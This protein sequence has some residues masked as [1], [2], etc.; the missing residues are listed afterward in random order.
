MQAI[1]NSLQDYHPVSQQLAEFKAALEFYVNR[2]PQ[3]SNKECIE[4]LQEDLPVELLYS[5]DVIRAPT[6]LF[7]LLRDYIVLK[8][9]EY[10][11]HP[12]NNRIIYGIAFSFF[13]NG[14]D[15]D[16]ALQRLA[17]IRGGAP[18]AAQ[19]A[20]PV[21][22]APVA[23]LA[24]EQEDERR[25]AHN[26]SQRFKKDDKFTGKL[27]ENLQDFLNNY[28]EACIDYSFTPEQKLKYL[29]NLFEGEAKAFYREHVFTVCHSYPE[30]CN[31]LLAK[32]NNI[33][34]QIRVR[35][36]LQSLSLNAIVSK[37]S[38]D[39]SEGLE[40]LRNTIVKFAPQ[41]PM[42][43]RSEE[44]KVEYLYNAV[45]N[46]EWAKN[47]LTQCYAQDPPWNF[48][49]LFTALD[50]AWLQEQ[51]RTSTISASASDPSTVF[52]DSQQTYGR[53][54]NNR[55]KP[56]LPYNKRNHKVRCYNCNEIGHYAWQCSKPRN[57]T[58]NVRSITNKHPKRSNR[59]LYEIC[60]Q[61]DQSSLLQNEEESTSLDSDTTSN[62]EPDE[63]TKLVDT[64]H[65]SNTFNA[66]DF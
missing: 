18:N 43:Y 22:H 20:P 28:E 64:L 19:V 49:Q 57:M 51:R 35:Q 65:N 48:Y 46:C 16:F 45:V 26:I 27:G 47:A 52:W 36:Y 4:G 42:S 6:I 25:L 29:H 56:K 34:R 38:C 17:S 41:G 39:V 60:Q 13:D 58:N 2:D 8:G 10:T 32:F 21:L 7:R 59:I 37:E 15:S 33:S 31:T 61:F 55:P 63:E 30:A 40:K 23:N 5:E 12:A 54:R 62:D 24:R 11:Q 44:A 50:T 14:D 9:F 66:E 3:L 1:R 53:P